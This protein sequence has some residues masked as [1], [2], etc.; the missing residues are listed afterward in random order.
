MGAGR[1]PGTEWGGGQRGLN[2]IIS[3]A[4]TITTKSDDA[5]P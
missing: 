4:T 5:Y 3:T 2:E 1:V